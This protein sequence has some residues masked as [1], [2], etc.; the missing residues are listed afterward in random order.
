MTAAGSG[1]VQLAAL[2]VRLK[3]AGDK[4]LR[5]ELLRGLK[6]GAEPLVP[7]VKAAA[8][9][10]LPHKGG[11]NEQ[12]AGQKVTVQVRMGAR[13]AGVRMTT[14]APDTK[15]TDAGFVRH[16]V[17]ARKTVTKTKDAKGKTKKTSKYTLLNG[18]G[19]ASALGYGD[20]VKV[21]WVTQ[22]IPAAKGWWSETLAN[23]APIVQPDLAAAME[24]VALEIQGGI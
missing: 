18:G 4:T 14:T 1:S 13:T 9:E 22:K 11:L 19:Y 2:A 8:L 24:R 17:F 12:V 23:G 16:P 10:K 21:P 7:L 20:A 5:R 3:V 15:Q 6:S